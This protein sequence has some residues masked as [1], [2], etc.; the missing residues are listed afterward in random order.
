M[1][2]NELRDNE[3]AVKDRMRVGR[4][5][6]SGKGKTGGRGVKG[7]KSR[8]GVAI[9]GFEGGQ[10]PLHRRLPKRGFTNIF[11]K[12]YNVVSLGRVQTAIEAGKLDGSQTV[13]VEALKAAGVV[14]RVRDGVRLVSDGE[15]K[16]AVTFEIAGASKAAIAAVEK[17]G[18]KVV[19][20]GAQA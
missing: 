13:T 10:M 4:G 16:S 2:L 9:K 15:L 18:G 17:A 3:G 6:G 11:A 8:S 12:D 7:Q 5:I 1:K 14:K 19:V 20:P